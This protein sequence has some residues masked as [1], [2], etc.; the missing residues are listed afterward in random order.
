MN[1][2]IITIGVLLLLGTVAAAI[3]NEYAPASQEPRIQI[4]IHEPAA[5]S[6]DSV[7][8]THAWLWTSTTD[9]AG[10]VVEPEDPSE[11]ELSFHA[12]GRVTSTTDCN[13]ISGQ[14]VINE[15]VLSMGQFMATE[16]YCG[17]DTLEE[18]Y[19]ARLALVSSYTLEGDDLTMILFKDGGTMTFKKKPVEGVDET[20]SIDG[21]EEPVSSDEA[22]AE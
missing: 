21:A 12:D 1:K 19:A 18:A 5:T 3:V 6:S 9:A 10:D 2:I 11:F 16:M 4:P 22:Q 7:L 20:G 13:G 15:E 8:V 14:Y 17:D